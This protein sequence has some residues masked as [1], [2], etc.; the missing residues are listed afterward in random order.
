MALVA[1]LACVLTVSERS[2]AAL[3]SE[4][5]PLT[6]VL[7][8]T[9]AALQAGTI[10]WQH[11]RIMVDETA[12]LDPA[13]AAALEAHFLDPDAPDPGPRVPRRGA[14]SR[15]GSGPRPGPGA[16]A[17]TRPASKNAT[18]KA[19]QDRRVEYCPDRDGM[20]WL[21]AYLPADT[22]AGIWERTT[23]AARALQRPDETRTLSQLRA[24]IAATWLLT[25]RKHRRPAD[26]A[27]PAGG[28]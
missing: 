21:S 13:G 25:S 5:R 10:S 17:T 15:A 16:N 1:E 28:A 22:A 3:L 9:L 14:A 7:P 19:P 6:T 12:N 26:N 24:D 11:A 2:A 23:A 8:L 18:P 4:A 27:S 20:A